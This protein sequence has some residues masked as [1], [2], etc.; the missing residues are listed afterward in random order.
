MQDINKEVGRRIRVLRMN[1]GFSQEELAFTS[2]IHRSHMGEIERGR[3]NITLKT[4]QRV[5]LGLR[6]S[7]AELVRSVGEN[8]SIKR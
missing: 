7:V 2:G 8:S 6:V 4:L 5:G 3:C 1:K